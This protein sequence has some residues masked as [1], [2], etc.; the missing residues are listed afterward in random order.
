MV[1]VPRV[2]SYSPAGQVLAVPESAVVDTGSRTVVFVD[3]GQGMFEGVEVVLGPRCGDEFPVVSGLQAGERVATSGGFLLDAETRLNPSLA[4]GYFGAAR[5]GSQ[6]AA[7]PASTPT[8]ET[9]THEA[10][11]SA[12]GA[13]VARQKVCPVTGKELGSM[14]TPVRVT[15]AGQDVFLCCD[16]CEAALRK[17]PEKYLS[18]LKSK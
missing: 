17:N 11:S 14:G 9:A 10:F 15:V 12:E 6:T 5:S 8:G 2:V 18:R 7:S 4:A 3:R 16:G 13:Q 1:L